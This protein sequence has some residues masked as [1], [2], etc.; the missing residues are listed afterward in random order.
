MRT[1][2]LSSHVRFASF[3]SHNRIISQFFPDCCALSKLL[4][5]NSSVHC[6]VSASTLVQNLTAIRIPRLILSTLELESLQQTIISLLLT[7]T[8]SKIIWNFSPHCV[9]QHC[10]LATSLNDQLSHSH[11]FQDGWWQRWVSPVS[12]LRPSVST[13]FVRR[14][15]MKICSSTCTNHLRRRAQKPSHERSHFWHR[16]CGGNLQIKL[17]RR[18]CLCVF[19]ELLQKDQHRVQKILQTNTRVTWADSHISITVSR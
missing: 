7:T 16:V 18:T 13:V 2:L 12:G 15:R 19:D 5:M 17:Q 1:E 4:Q 8:I 9:H 11:P 14:M 10:Y 6:Q 3:T